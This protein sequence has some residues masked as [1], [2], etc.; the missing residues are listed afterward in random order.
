M[1]KNSIYFIVLLPRCRFRYPSS[2]SSSSSS[3]IISGVTASTTFIAPPTTVVVAL[4]AAEVA[5]TAIV[6][7]AVCVNSKSRLSKT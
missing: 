2:S 4:I 3:E 1:K 6:T 7:Q 5:V